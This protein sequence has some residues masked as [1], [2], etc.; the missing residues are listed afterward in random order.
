MSI[1]E[2]AARRTKVT[3][4]R[5]LLVAILLGGAVPRLVAILRTTTIEMDGISY[6]TIAREFLHGHFG[7]ALNN[8]FP[9]LYPLF[10]SLFHFAIPD[11]ELAGRLTSLAF[12]L[13]TIVLVYYFVR[14]LTGSDGKALW[15]AF[16]VC[17]QP[18]LMRYSGQV[19]SESTTSFLFAATVFAFYI[20]WAE[21]RP[22]LIA[23]SG[24]CLSLTYLTRPEYVVYYAPFALVLLARKRFGSMVL[25]FLPFLFLG[26][27]Y[28]LYLHS[29][30]GL[31]VVSNKATLSPFVPIGLFLR[32]LPAVFYEFIVALTPV[33]AL[34]VLLGIRSTRRSYGLIVA[35]LVFFHIVSLAFV[36]HATKR[37]SVEFIP[38]CS[39][40]AVEGIYWIV[41][42]CRRTN[43]SSA[44]PVIIAVLVGAIGILQSY[45]T[46][47]KDRALHKEAGLCLKGNAPGSVIASRLPLVAF[48]GEG[49]NVDLL[50]AVADKTNP[51]RLRQALAETGSQ[52]L[53]VDEESE[54]ELPSLK[55]W[56]AGRV[57]SREFANG[58]HFLRLYRLSDG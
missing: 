47:R 24:L 37:Y 17:F 18:Y 6:A 22:S 23:L 21:E 50:R 28:I 35:L 10:M 45:E 4:Y 2:S 27:L 41:G 13:L 1:H 19:L 54:I 20:G 26:T 16:L 42:F 29:Q 31:W 48:Y 32:N 56:S 15:G 55:A 25:L 9:P 51:D 3:S 53:V 43:L 58:R 5:F 11:V 30:T 40:F 38:V 52:Y 8:I 39:I 34:L 7:A 14:K 49:R 46:P 44:V 12:G 57:P 36:G 33:Y